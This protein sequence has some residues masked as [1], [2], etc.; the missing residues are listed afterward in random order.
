M[1]EQQ[2]KAPN[3]DKYTTQH[4]N[5]YQ[6][7][8]L[9]KS[10]C[11]GGGGG[12]CVASVSYVRICA[13]RAA[14]SGIFCAVWVQAGAMRRHFGRSLCEGSAPLAMPCLVMQA[15]SSEGQQICGSSSLALF[16]LASTCLTVCSLETPDFGRKPLTR[17]AECNCPAIIPQ[18]AKEWTHSIEPSGSVHGAF[19]FKTLYHRLQGNSSGCFTVATHLLLSE[20]HCSMKLLARSACVRDYPENR[21]SSLVLLKSFRMTLCCWVTTNYCR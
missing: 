3:N 7:P 18:H 4:N 11:G 6:W 17:L 8:C 10:V 14:W 12:H 13:V 9:H 15:G 2:T 19:A 5:Q 1:T 21:F 20:T 16:L